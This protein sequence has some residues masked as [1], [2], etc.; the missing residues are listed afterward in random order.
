VIVISE[1]MRSLVSVN[2][3]LS[4]GHFTVIQ[5]WIDE[6]EFPVWKGDA[7]W[8]HSQ[9]IRDGLFVAMFAGTLG[10]VSGVEVL[11]D[12][13]RILQEETNV[14]LLCIGEGGQKQAMVDEASRLG[15][16]NIRFLPFQPSNRVSEVQASC[17]VTLLTMSPN[18]SN[19]SVPSKLISYLAASRPVICAANAESD[20]ARS[21][22]EANAGLAVSPG[23]AQAIAD[24]ILRLKREPEKARQ[25]GRNARRYFEEH[26]TLERAYRQFSELLRKTETCEEQ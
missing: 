17:D 11:V 10:H 4:R 18:Y 25:M 1:T 22:L 6:S 7:A 13:A 2:R 5:N 26:Y 9:G 15:L 12:V 23:D 24:A 19:T 21:V 3:Q 14:I 16:K 8:R 20:V